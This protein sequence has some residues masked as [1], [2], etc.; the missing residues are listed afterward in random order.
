MKTKERTLTTAE[1][2]RH[3]IYDVD[4]LWEGPFAEVCDTS[5]RDFLKEARQL[6]KE[7]AQEEYSFTPEGRAAFL[8][9]AFY[10]LGAWSGVLKYRSSIVAEI[11][12]AADI[13]IADIPEDVCFQIDEGAVAGI[14]SGLDIQPDLARELCDLF[15][16]P[17]EKAE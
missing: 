17:I 2:T 9:W 7:L 12:E 16:L 13:K 5:L 14:V 11:E 8:C 15:H 3:H 6:A 1:M 4:T 10:T